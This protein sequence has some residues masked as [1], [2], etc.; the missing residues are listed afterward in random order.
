[1][2]E[3]GAAVV[4]W[5]EGLG[6]ALGEGIAAMEERSSV[7]GEKVEMILNVYTVRI[8]RM[9]KARGILSMCHGSQDSNRSRVA[10]QRLTL[11]S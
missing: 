9:M 8:K 10:V 7:Y 2:D 11:L 4:A 1:M 5:P 3:G 6:G